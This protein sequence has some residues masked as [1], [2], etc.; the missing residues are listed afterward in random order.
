[1]IRGAERVLEKAKADRE[2]YPATAYDEAGKRKDVETI[3]RKEEEDEKKRQRELGNA[4]CTPIVEVT[5]A[6]DLDVPA[7]TY[8]PP[9]SQSQALPAGI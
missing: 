6:M 1:M 3:E 9:V 7:R 4:I 2:K 8:L 5:E